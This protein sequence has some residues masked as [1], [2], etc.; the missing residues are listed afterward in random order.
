[1]YIQECR[2]NDCVTGNT[3][4]AGEREIQER[5]ELR[6]CSGIDA[7]KHTLN[8][9]RHALGDGER[10]WRGLFDIPVERRVAQYLGRNY[11]R[12]GRGANAPVAASTPREADG[13]AGCANRKRSGGDHGG[14][15][16]RMRLQT[17]ARIKTT[18]GKREERQPL[19]R[20]LKQPHPLK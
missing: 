8:I 9:R 19:P 18:Y 4:R 6:E 12:G 14:F 20:L 3:S 1:M 5:P 2:L 11:R 17:R 10:S 7:G 16:W 15:L 13:N